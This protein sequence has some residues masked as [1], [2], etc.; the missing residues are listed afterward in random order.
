[1]ETSKMRSFLTL[2]A[3]GAPGSK[4]EATEQSQGSRWTRENRKAHGGSAHGGSAHRPPWSRSPWGLCF[5]S[6]SSTFCVCC[7]HPLLPSMP[8]LV[9]ASNVRPVTTTVRAMDWPWPVRIL[10]F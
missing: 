6:F 3:S 4:E 5:A 9:A 7:A 8:G 10:Q 1:M 2:V